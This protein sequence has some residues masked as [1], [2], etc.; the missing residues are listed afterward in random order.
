[1]NLKD[2]YERTVCACDECRQC[3]KKGP[4]YLLPEDLPNFSINELQASLRTKILFSGMREFINVP[5]L[6][7]RTKEDG[8]CV[9]LDENERCMIHDRS[10]WG[11]SHFDTHQE[12]DGIERSKAGISNLLSNGKEVGY[13]STWHTVTTLHPV[14]LNKDDDQTEVLRKMFELRDSLLQK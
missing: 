14:L 4:G 10:P 11:C 1:M 3:C 9:F 7:P 6:V 2:K 5:T 8:S 12:E 13:W